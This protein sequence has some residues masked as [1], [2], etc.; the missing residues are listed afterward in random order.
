MCVF[1]EGEVG[2]GGVGQGTRTSRLMG[3]AMQPSTSP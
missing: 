3:R 2:W 1:P